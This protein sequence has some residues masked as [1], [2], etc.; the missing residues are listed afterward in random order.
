MP[1]RF[2]NDKTQTCTCVLHDFL[3]HAV[4]ILQQVKMASKYYQVSYFKQQQQQQRIM[5][6]IFV[7]F[8]VTTFN[9]YRCQKH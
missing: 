5:L 4:C 6:M 3:N 7:C 9:A 2:A 8:F 1:K